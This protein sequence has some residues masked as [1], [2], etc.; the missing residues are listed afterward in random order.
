MNTIGSTS[1]KMNPLPPSDF[2]VPHTLCLVRSFKKWT[3]RDLLPGNFPAQ[4]LAEKIFNAPFVIVSHGTQADPVLN[5]GNRTALTLLG[6]V[7]G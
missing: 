5:Y 4:E 7:L 1:P 2:V 3:G 6:D